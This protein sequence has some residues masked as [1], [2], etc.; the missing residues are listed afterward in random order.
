[1]R[2]VFKSDAFVLSSKPY[3]EADK[4]VTLYSKNDGKITAI[5]K[6]VRRLSSKKRGSLE[7]FCLIKFQA[8]Q[9]H[10]MP[11][12][13]ETSLINSFS[14]LRANLKAMSVAYYFSEV[15]MKT[16]QDGEQNVDLYNLLG[17]S[18]SSLNTGTSLKMLR[19]D[20]AES[21][22]RLL[23]YWPEDKPI[24][25]PDYALEEVIEKKLSSVRVGKKLNL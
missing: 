25:N 1:M 2:N 3:S 10:G 24:L 16:Q 13:T 11:I 22:L 4:I 6:G 20:F 17:R 14:S 12:I 15:I 18:I 19:I 21:A 23:G 9:T 7:S 8:V 5:A